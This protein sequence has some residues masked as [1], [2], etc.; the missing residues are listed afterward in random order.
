MGRPHPPPRFGFADSR[1]SLLFAGATLAVTI[2]VGCSS[3]TP[4]KIGSFCTAAE[5]VKSTC[6]NPGA[7]DGPLT[8]SC[9]NLDKALSPAV[10]TAAKDC[11]ESGVCGATSCLGRAQNSGA[12][13]DAHLSLATKFCGSCAPDLA[14]CEKQFYAKKSKLPGGLV[15]PYAE[16]IARAVEE[17][18][19]GDAATC[20]AQFASCASETIARVAAESL[21][22][23]L[24]DC[25]VTAF[26]REESGPSGPG[27]GV[28][29]TT[30]TPDNCDG[31]CLDDRC[32]KG[33]TEL[34]CGVGGAA[35]Q[36]CSGAQTCKTGGC[37]E[38]CGSSN[39]AGCCDG[40]VCQ[41]GTETGA[42]GGEGGACSKCTDEGAT[43]IC[44]NKQ[45]IDGSCQANCPN[46]CCS[47]TGCQPG[48]AAKGCGTGG[49][50]C[51]SCGTGRTCDGSTRACVIDEDALW[52]LVVSYAK[53][54]ATDKSGRTWDT[55]N[56]APDAYVKALSKEGA[57]THSGETRVVDDSTVPVWS[58]T[59]LSGIKS[60]E[61]LSSLSFEIWDSDYDYDDYIGGC[62]VGLRALNFDGTLQTVKCSASASAV[63]VEIF[64]RINPRP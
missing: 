41:P 64:F 18:C 12:P 40:D 11:L 43:Y 16:S 36:K 35:C 38:P 31:C 7:C 44:S 3:V 58:Q 33:D 46:G 34:R 53:V 42:C 47:A 24:A 19:T 4:L 32:E 56:A 23:E 25:T 8:T 28:T 59:V 21:G 29:V 48:T 14:D 57:S 62:A 20:R 1:P 6:K 37:K 17:S 27:G 60:S 2:G 5:S 50:G 55:L 13:T 26:R 52:D 45:C 9:A 22:P 10:L 49:E 54:P 51:Y 63:A 15:L 39:C 61:L 30:C